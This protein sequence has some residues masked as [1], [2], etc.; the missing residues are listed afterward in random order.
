VAPIEFGIF[1][2]VTRPSGVALDELYGMPAVRA[3]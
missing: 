1:D 3:L 2:H